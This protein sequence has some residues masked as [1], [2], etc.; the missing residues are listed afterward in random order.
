MSRGNPCVQCGACCAFF[1]V[2]FFWEEAT[3]DDPTA[4][5]TEYT[6]ENDDM[7]QCMKGTNQHSPRCIA[8]QGE[9]G[10][11]VSCAIYERRSSTCRD[12][13]LQE[14]NRII[15]VNGV[16]LIRCNQ[17]RKSWNLPP[18]NRAELRSL[19]H[20]LSIRVAP[21]PN[22]PYNKNNHRHIF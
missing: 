3:P 20:A 19:P 15:S 18:L 2:S 16:D 12:F 8:L 21:T 7:F 6:E 5:P 11:Q 10:K 9:I 22:H 4:V 17:A 13:G 1:R 14:T